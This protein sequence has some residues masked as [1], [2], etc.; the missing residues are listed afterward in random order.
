MKVADSGM[1]PDSGFFLP[2]AITISIY[3]YVEATF[4]VR[5][6]LEGNEHW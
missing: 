1:L 6:K 2:L 5:P 3:E 4:Q